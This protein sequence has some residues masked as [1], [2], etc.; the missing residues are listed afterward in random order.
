MNDK[1]KK[2]VIGGVIFILIA[3]IGNVAGGGG[4]GVKYKLDDA[5]AKVVTLKSDEAL[6]E[7][8]EEYDKAL[9]KLTDEE[10]N[11]EISFGKVQY[12]LNDPIELEEL[13]NIRVS[14]LSAVIHKYV[15]DHKAAEK[16]KKEK[17]N[18]ERIAKAKELEKIKVEKRKSRTR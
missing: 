7:F 1:T 14:D 15:T 8:D 10:K 2:W 17:E 5:V 9:K 4:S 18:A 3:I 16:L 6:K 13:Q 11:V 12:Y